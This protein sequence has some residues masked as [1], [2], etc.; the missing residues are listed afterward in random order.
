MQENEPQMKQKD[1][2][3]LTIDNYYSEIFST[4]C[5]TPT[6]YVFVSC[7]KVSVETMYVTV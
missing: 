7:F 2:Q 6:M 4:H 5:A 3:T 1:K